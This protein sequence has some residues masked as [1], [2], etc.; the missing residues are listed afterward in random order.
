MQIAVIGG[1]GRTGRLFG[2]HALTAGHT[3][4]ILARDS[5]KA[6]DLKDRF[7]IKQG[8]VRDAGV[9]KAL[10][11]G[12]D[13]VVCL[14]GA[15]QTKPGTIMSEGTQIIVRSMNETG[16]RRLILVSSDGVGETR[17]GLPLTLR[18]GTFFVR[19]Y[20]AEKEA[21]EKI[22]RASDLD[23]TIVRPG[24]LTG[25]PIT[26]KVATSR[27]GRETLWEG[28]PRRPGG[29][30]PGTAGRSLNHPS[31][32]PTVRIGLVGC[33]LDS[34]NPFH[35]KSASRVLKTRGFEPTVSCLDGD[36]QGR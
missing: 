31:V 2:E 32:T 16:V 33:L 8:D 9:V 10:I 6:G 35:S 11:V 25:S 18:L 19:E 22:V 5:S 20:M 27:A 14:L 21:Q 24:Q 13:A 30:P 15:S 12:V 34:E 26:G 7:E 4:R 36:A 3:V 17:A 29:V 23:W 1:A 28:R